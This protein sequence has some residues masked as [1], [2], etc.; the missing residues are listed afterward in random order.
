ML[1]YHFYDSESD[2]LDYLEENKD[3][4]QCIVGDGRIPFGKAQQ[5]SLS[6]YADGVDTLKWLNQLK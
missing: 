5:P 6:D 3:Q 4:L 1:Y 2:I